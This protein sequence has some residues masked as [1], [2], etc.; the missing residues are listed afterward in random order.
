MVEIRSY[1][2]SMEIL[3]LG[4]RFQNN[5]ELSTNLYRQIWEISV[6]GKKGGFCEKKD[7]D[8]SLFL[9]DKLRGTTM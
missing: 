5:I 8:N 2:A 9:R 4:D 3:F 6:Y 7:L 1:K